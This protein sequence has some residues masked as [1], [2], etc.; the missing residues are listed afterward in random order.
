MELIEKI[1]QNSMR[2]IGS[3]IEIIYDAGIDLLNQR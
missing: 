1:T 2:N 3:G